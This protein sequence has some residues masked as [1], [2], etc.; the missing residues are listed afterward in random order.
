MS[1]SETTYL[2]L[3]VIML[4]LTVIS[5]TAFEGVLRYVIGGI[6]LIGILYGVGMLA[7]VRKSGS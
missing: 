4:L 5:L 7:R 6:G 2:S 3:T 1:K